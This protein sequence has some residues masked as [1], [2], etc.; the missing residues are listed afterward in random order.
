MRKGQ[1]NKLELDELNDDS[2]YNTYQVRLEA[3]E[4]WI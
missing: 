2:S 4:A 1:K 3:Q